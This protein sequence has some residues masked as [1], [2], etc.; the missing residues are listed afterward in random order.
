VTEWDKVTV[1]RALSSVPT[2]YRSFSSD[3]KANK[4]VITL[5]YSDITYNSPIPNEIDSCE[6]NS[7]MA[8][9]KN[10]SGCV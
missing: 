2:S 10:T 7:L 3:A 4:T 8:V 9:Q 5:P 6:T 1:F